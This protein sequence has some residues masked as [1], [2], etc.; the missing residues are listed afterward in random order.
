MMDMMR[1]TRT[2]HVSWRGLLH[3][4]VALAIAAS[5]AAPAGSVQV[6]PMIGRYRVSGGGGTIPILTR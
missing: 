4:A 2:R 1:P 6:D 3:M 5:C